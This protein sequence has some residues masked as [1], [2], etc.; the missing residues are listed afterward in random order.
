LARARRSSLEGPCASWS[1]A[2]RSTSQPR[3]GAH[4]LAVHLAQVVRVRLG[5]RRERAEDSGHVGVDVGQGRDRGTPAGGTGT[6]A[7][8]GHDATLLPARDGAD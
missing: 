3:G 1:W 4:A 6:A 8:S 7:G 2:S 5:V